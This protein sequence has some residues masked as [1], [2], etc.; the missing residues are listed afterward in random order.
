MDLRLEELEASLDAN[1]YSGKVTSLCIRKD[2]GI[3]Q[4]PE[5]IEIDVEKGVIGDRWIW[6]TWKHLE[7]GDSDPRVQVAVCNSR[8]LQLLQKEKNNPYH[9]GDNIVVDYDL[10]AEDFPVGQRFTVGE[11]VLE[12]SDVY[13]DACAKFAGEFGNDVIKWINLPEHR[14]L[15]LRG[16]YCRTIRGGKVKLGDSI[17]R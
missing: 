15:N 8:I 12:V 4:H 7:N 13:N 5:A 14:D 16:I 9:P 1:P 6:R 17:S 11:V 3:R 10:K 2:N